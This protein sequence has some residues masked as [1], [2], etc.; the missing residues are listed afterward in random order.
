MDVN[1]QCVRNPIELHRVPEGCLDHL[2]MAQDLGSMAA[3]R[4]GLIEHPNF[5]GF[6]SFGLAKQERGRQRT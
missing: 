4:G 1:K 2:G 6:R 5:G 3:N